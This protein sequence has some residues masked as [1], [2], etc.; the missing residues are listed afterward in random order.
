MEADPQQ[1]VGT[2][3]AQGKDFG[4]LQ[5]DAIALAELIKHYASTV[6][7]IAMR[8]MRSGDWPAHP[9]VAGLEIASAHV[10]FVVGKNEAIRMDDPKASPAI[11]AAQK[12]SDLMQAQDEELLDLAREVGPRAAKAYRQLLKAIGDSDD[13][14]V[15]WQSPGRPPVAVTSVG[16]ARAFRVL[17]REGESESDE[18]TV[19]GH[20]S[21]ADAELNKFKLKLFKG[22][23]RPPQLKGKRVVHGHYD[24]P[25]G[26]LVKEQGLWDSD[27]EAEIYI[28]RERAETVATPR[29]P[30]FILLSVKKSS[31]PPPRKGRPSI[32]GS[33][34]LDEEV[35]G[36]AE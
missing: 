23:P 5:V 16:A 28:E 8:R 10:Q 3:V 36:R 20:L 26:Q 17:D 14:E 11:E 18:F 4:P 12:V 9:G 35:F 27:V 13:A 1:E 21:M 29:D 25:V 22:A 15:S 33:V 34:P 2:L 30:K 19:L 32:P 31:A 7:E 6:Y 24:N